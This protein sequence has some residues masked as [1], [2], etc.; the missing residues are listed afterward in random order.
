MKVYIEI[1]KSITWIFW[2]YI[3]IKSLYLKAILKVYIESLYWKI[4]QLVIIII[5]LEFDAFF[6][7]F[8][9]L[10]LFRV[11]TRSRFLVRRLPLRFSNKNINKLILKQGKLPEKQVQFKTLDLLC[12][13]WA[14]KFKWLVRVYKYLNHSAQRTGFL[15]SILVQPAV[16]FPL[17]FPNF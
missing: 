1:W 13:M 17:V 2:M 16:I 9:P 15:K 7:L 12:I 4:N 6:L 8:L 10:A 3:Y 11:R 5:G 14:A